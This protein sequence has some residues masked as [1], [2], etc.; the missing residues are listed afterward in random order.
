[1]DAE[2]FHKKMEEVKTDIQNNQR[3]HY[4]HAGIV[5][6]INKSIQTSTPINMNYHEKLNE[7]NALVSAIQV[8]TKFFRTPPFNMR[9]DSP[10]F[11]AEGERN[12]FI[13]LEELA[14]LQEVIIGYLS[15]EDD[16]EH[17]IEEFADVMLALEYVKSICNIDEESIKTAMDVKIDRLL[18]RINENGSYV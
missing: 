14:E 1:M 7:L 4:D 9:L 11:H 5:E 8:D 15:G 10:S 12:L 3:D 6:A 2:K 17:I 13:V 16:H 18:E